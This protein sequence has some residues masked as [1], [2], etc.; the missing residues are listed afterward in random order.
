LA[1]EPLAA[2][3]LLGLGLDEFSMS[4]ARVPVI[5]QVMRKLHKKECAEFVQ[6]VLDKTNHEEVIEESTAFLKELGIEL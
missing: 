1:G 2:P 6:K 4:P 3:I 5:K